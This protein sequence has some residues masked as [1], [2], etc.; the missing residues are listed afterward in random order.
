M[1]DFNLKLLLK[2]ELSVKMPSNL[3]RELVEESN[4]KNKSLRKTALIESLFEE[5]SLDE[6]K[7]MILSNENKRRKKEN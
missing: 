6:I 5:Y 3:F 1:N 7:D 2:S 4:I